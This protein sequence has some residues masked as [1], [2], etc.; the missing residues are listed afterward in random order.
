MFG[1]HAVVTLPFGDHPQR[2]SGQW[3]WLRICQRK[4]GF[5]LALQGL[6]R[7]PC[8]MKPAVWEKSVHEIA[9]CC[10]SQLRTFAP[11]K[12]ILRMPGIRIDDGVDGSIR[13]A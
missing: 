10:S 13:L 7:L 9:Y 12:T 1:K 11:P 2:D 5:Q 8:D 6:L 4:L 3:V